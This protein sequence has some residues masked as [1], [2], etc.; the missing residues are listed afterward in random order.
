MLAAAGGLLPAQARPGAARRAR[1]RHR[2]AWRAG[3]AARLRPSPYANPD[4]P[5]GG[6]LTQGVLGTF[7]SLNPFIVKGLALSQIRGYV[8]ESLLARGYDEPFTLYGLLARTVET[9]AERTYVT[10]A[11][12]PAAKFSDGTAGHRRRRDLFLAA[13]A[14][15]R[16]AEPP[17]LL[18]QGRQ[19]RDARRAHGALRS[20]RRQRP[21][22]AAD[23]RPDAGAGQARHQPRHLRGHDASS[24]SSAAAP[25]WSPRSTPARASRS[26]AIRITGAA[27]FRSTAASGTSTSS[28]STTTAT[29]IRIFEAFK[30]GLYDVR[31]ETDPGR[32]QTAYDF[33]A[34]R[35]GR[36]RQGS[37][38]NGLPKAVLG[39]RLQHPAA[40]LRRH[41]RARGDRAAVRLRMG[42]PQ[43]LLRSL[44][45]ARRATS[46]AP[47]CRRDGRPADARERA[48][49][50]PFPGSG[51]RRR[52]STAP[53]RRRS[54]DGSGRD[55]DTLQARARPA[56][57]RRLR[58]RRHGAAL[59]RDAAA[60]SA[61]RSWSPAATRSG[62]RSP[63]A[64][65]QARR[66]RG[67]GPPGRR[68]A[69]RPAATARFDFD[70]IEYR[71]DQSLSPGNEQAST[72]A[73][74]RPTPTAPA[75]TWA[76][77]APRSTP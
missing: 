10:F 41:P 18:R 24:R 62:S 52:A 33:P 53:G 13:A 23:P 19:G 25:T 45:S 69:I 2:H 37:V 65:P 42:Q 36:D 35:D 5:K 21:R 66:H 7:D 64:R 44:P 51:A 48:L 75:T 49:L 68:R 43:F 38:P 39:P 58:A 32:W 27:T 50:A 71:W 40:D 26:S 67:A 57:R 56:R 8:V 76:S 59:A 54:A 29:P 9:D 22:I 11:L 77:K 3:A 60:A 47:S 55:R 6:R 74:P 70:M 72:G 1:T 16:P 12:D 61:S 20:D 34:V 46:T 30:T 73:R 28:A 15:Q 17:H 14:R 4:A 63:F 31:I